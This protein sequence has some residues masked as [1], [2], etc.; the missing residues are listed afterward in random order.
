MSWQA[1]AGSMGGGIASGAFSYFGAREANRMGRDMSREQMQFQERMS[2]TAHQREVRDLKLAGLNPILSATGGG[3]SSPSGAMPNIRS[4]A[5]G[6]SSS[7]LAVPRMMA[8]IRAVN[9]GADLSEAKTKTEEGVASGART[10]EL[11]NDLEYDILKQLDSWVR[12]T[13]AGVTAAAT[14]AVPI[15]RAGPSKFKHSDVYKKRN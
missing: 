4:A 1:G 14:K 10:R 7:A 2:N 3:S 13:G 9:A 11:K 8:D 6:A 12:K 15:Y 5:E